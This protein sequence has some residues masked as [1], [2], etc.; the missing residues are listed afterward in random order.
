MFQCQ[1]VARMAAPLSRFAQFHFVDHSNTTARLIPL[2]SPL[3]LW[4]A[5][6]FACVPNFARVLCPL[7]LSLFPLSI[8]Q[9]DSISHEQNKDPSQMNRSLL[10]L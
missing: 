6:S 7:S 3:L 10:L 1:S 9:K 4:L 5:S 8:F 2:R